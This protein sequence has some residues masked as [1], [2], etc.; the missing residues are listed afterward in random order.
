MRD[1]HFFANETCKKVD[2]R[3]IYS[4][5]TAKYL[6]LQ[7]GFFAKFDKDWPKP[8]HFSSKRGQPRF[9]ESSWCTQSEVP[10]N[11]AFL[12]IKASSLVISL[13]QNS[14]IEVS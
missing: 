8:T 10:L 3:Q 13:T 1:R 5:T 4:N 7:S 2:L 14:R 9:K 6:V 11:E 12:R